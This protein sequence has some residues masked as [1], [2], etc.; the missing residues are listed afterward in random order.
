MN[1]PASCKEINYFIWLQLVLTFFAY[2]PY[3]LFVSSNV[4]VWTFIINGMFTLNL[5]AQFVFE[6]LYLNCLMI[7]WKSF[8]NLNKRITEIKSSSD[9]DGKLGI[10]KHTYTA[11]CDYAV[12]VNTY[13]KTPIII[14]VF[15]YFI[16][17]GFSMVSL[18]SE[19]VVHDSYVVSRILW[20]LFYIFTHVW[21][22]FI[23][24]YCL[25][26]VRDEVS[27]KLA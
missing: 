8:K 17:T 19:I 4:S 3:L 1:G 16:R 21:E 13:F 11:L 12:L 2:A 26:M 27:R 15:A 24:F 5:Y 20:K 22:N 9:L 23:I 10:I 7:A 6:L 18:F 25:G 14:Y